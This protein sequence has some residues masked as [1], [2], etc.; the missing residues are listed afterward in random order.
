[1]INID[2]IRKTSRLAKIDFSDDHM[3]DF[4]KD[5]NSIMQMIDSLQEVDCSEVVPLRSVLDMHQRL[6]EDVVSEDGI[7]N[8]LFQNIPEGGA[9]LAKEVKCFIVPKVVE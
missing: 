7:A 6:A 8:Q 3:S 4:L 9:E 2:D 5:L 1:M